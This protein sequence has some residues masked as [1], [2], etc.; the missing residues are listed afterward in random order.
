ML[1]DI[2]HVIF[3]TILEMTRNTVNRYSYFW[4]TETRAIYI[5]EIR[6]IKNIYLVNDGFRLESF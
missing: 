1:Y 3:I 2:S 5:N 6:P 4:F